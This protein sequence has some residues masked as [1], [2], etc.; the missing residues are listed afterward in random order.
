MKRALLLIMILISSHVHAAELS[1]ECVQSMQKVYKF[2]YQ[3]VT[4]KASC[5]KTQGFN[6]EEAAVMQAVISELK[7]NCPA[8]VVA[9]MSQIL[10]SESTAHS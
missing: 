1:D 3:E 8:T 7:T 2:F 5:Q 6:D 4:P 9:K 10:A